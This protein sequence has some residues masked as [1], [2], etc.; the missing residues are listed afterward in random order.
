MK[1]VSIKFVNP[2]EIY[3]NP[4]LKRRLL[5]LTNNRTLGST[6]KHWVYDETLLRVWV[7]YLDDKII[8]WGAYCISGLVGVFVQPHYRKR[9]YGLML[10][11]RIRKYASRKKEV[12]YVRPWNHAG[13]KMYESA[14]FD[15]PISVF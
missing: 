4:L 1:K 6:M 2:E 9:G 5:R 12:T 14:G 13:R 15:V 7:L 10:C 3:R 11:R 8:G